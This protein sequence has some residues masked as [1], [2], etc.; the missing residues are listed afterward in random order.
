MK[1]KVI[2]I[3]RGG[4]GNQLF[5]YAFGKSLAER[6]GFELVLN[7]K[8]GFKYDKLYKRKFLL[9]HFNHSGRL[10]SNHEMLIPFF[11][12]RRLLLQYLNDLLPNFFNNYILQKSTKYDCQIADIKLLKTTI[13]DGCWISE[14]YFKNYKNLIREELE[15]K[16]ELPESA[17]NLFNEIRNKNSVAIHVRWFNKPTEPQTHNLTSKYY[18]SAIAYIKK[19]IENPH[20]FIFTDEP[21]QIESKIDLQSLDYTIIN[22]DENQYSE[23]IDFVLMKHCKHF[24]IANS[25][26]SW[27]AAWLCDYTEKI[28]L[29]PEVSMNGLTTWGEENQVPDLW[30]KIKV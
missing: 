8:S 19:K 12:V 3:L 6:N 5:N 21:S 17:A 20:F 18:K 4:L 23:I 9:N 24:V 15:I 26:F 27:W 16:F 28:I 10:A 7:Y 29:T 11:K 14:E 2:V 22:N 30:I 25:T 1:K 13:I